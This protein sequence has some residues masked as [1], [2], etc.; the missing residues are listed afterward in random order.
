MIRKSHLVPALLAKP[1]TAGE[2]AA[3][4]NVHPQTAKVWVAQFLKAGEIE[5]VLPRARNNLP[6]TY[7]RAVV[8]S[9]GEVGGNAFT[10]VR[11]K[12]RG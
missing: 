5:M 12:G 3:A 2:I 6:Q 11:P 10:N 1:M 9:R 4:L 7:V 8:S